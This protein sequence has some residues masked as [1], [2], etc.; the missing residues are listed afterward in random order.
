MEWFEESFAVASSSVLAQEWGKVVG[1]AADEYANILTSRYPRMG[2]WGM[3]ERQFEPGTCAPLSLHDL[4]QRIYIY[5]GRDEGTFSS[6]PI[7]TTKWKYDEARVVATD[8]GELWKRLAKYA[9]VKCI[10]LPTQIT[11]IFTFY[12]RSRRRGASEISPISPSASLPIVAANHIS[13]LN[14]LLFRMHTGICQ[15]DI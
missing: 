13:L 7:L 3:M 10:N 2:G 14:I 9:T 11:L 5:E 8:A 1:G 12:S 4:L 15:T 6:S